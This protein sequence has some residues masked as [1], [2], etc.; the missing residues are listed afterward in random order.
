MNPLPNF[1][2]HPNPIATG[3]V[4]PSSSICR[5]CGQA[6]GYIYT[7]SVYASDSLQDSICPWCI[8]DGSAADKF[9]ALFSDPDPL[10]GAGVPDEVIDEVTRHTPG[11]N[12]WQ[13]EIW[14]S[15]CQDACEFHG[16]ATRD[17]LLALQGEALTRTLVAWRWRDQNWKQFVQHYQPGGNPAVY[18]FVCHHCR[19]PG[20]ALD[21]T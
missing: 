4:K 20:Y 16:D 10:A 2:Y 15:C 5:C 19:K 14:L 9:D 12:S 13:Q 3:S 8:A 21:F 7:S 6:R 17:E 18:K 1:R 11:Y